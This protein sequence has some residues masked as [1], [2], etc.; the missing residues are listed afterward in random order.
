[1]ISGTCPPDET[2]FDYVRQRTDDPFE[3]VYADPS[4]SYVKEYRFDVSKLEPLVA[5]PHSP[6]NRKRARECAGTPIDRAYIGYASYHS[7]VCEAK[8]IEACLLYS[9]ID[10]SCPCSS[11][12]ACLVSPAAVHHAVCMWP[13]CT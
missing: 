2:T 13:I 11:M 10:R 5:A 3:P 1:M 12:H 4:A 8:L 7:H 6:D 9:R